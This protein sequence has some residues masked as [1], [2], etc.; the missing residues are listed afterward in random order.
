MSDYDFTSLDEVH[1]RAPM[2]SP[3][4]LCAAKNQM[5]R[6]EAE[7]AGLHEMCKSY[8]DTIGECNA[9]NSVLEAVRALHYEWRESC[10]ECKMVLPCSTAKALGVEAVQSLLEGEG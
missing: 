4:P 6:L 8:A 1:S 7:N 9:E 10:N 2:P 3:C 5:I